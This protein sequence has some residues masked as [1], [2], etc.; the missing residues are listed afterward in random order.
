MVIYDIV[1]LYCVPQFSYCLK[2]NSLCSCFFNILIIKRLL[3]TGCWSFE[4]KMLTYQLT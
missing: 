4:I 2:I 3:S 1:A